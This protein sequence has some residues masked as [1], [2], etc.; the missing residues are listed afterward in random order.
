MNDV[1]EIDEFLLKAYK[2]S[3]LN[4]EKIKKYHDQDIE[5]CDFVVGHFVLLFN[6]ILH[7]FSEKFKVKWTGPLIITQVFRHGAFDL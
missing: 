7:L 2:T 6:S 1:N 3:T 5:K 4:N